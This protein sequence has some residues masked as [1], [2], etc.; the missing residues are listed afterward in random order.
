MSMMIRRIDMCM[1]RV[2][3]CLVV[4]CV[5]ECAKFVVCRLLIE[6][7]SVYVLLVRILID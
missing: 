2:C 7:Y 5:W 4:G 6:D 1:L 3:I